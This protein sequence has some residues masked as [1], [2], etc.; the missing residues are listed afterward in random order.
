MR[1][2]ILCE[3]GPIYKCVIQNF[4]WKLGYKY[5][6][7]PLG[8]ERYINIE[9]G[10]SNKATESTT[11]ERATEITAWILERTTNV[12]RWRPVHQKRTVGSV[13]IIYVTDTAA[14]ARYTRPAQTQ[15]LCDGRTLLCPWCGLIDLSPMVL[16]GVRRLFCCG[17]VNG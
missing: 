3:R 5:I 11:A 9:L 16:P 14:A 6:I 1:D 15:Q 8:D 12:C 13:C 2:I 4:F 7:C 10:G 17:R